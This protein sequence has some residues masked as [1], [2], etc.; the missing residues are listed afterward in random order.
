[1]RAMEEQARRDSE[2]AES[3]L[4]FGDGHLPEARV[5]GDELDPTRAEKA[6]NKERRQQ[7]LA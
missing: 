6:E 1:M 4:R 2:L 7:K 5:P 3:R